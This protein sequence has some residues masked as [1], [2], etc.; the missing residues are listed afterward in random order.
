VGKVVNKRELAEILGYSE[1]SLT[2]WQGAGMPMLSQGDRG[3]EN[4]YDT[5]AVIKW[6]V[7]RESGKDKVEGEKERLTRLQADQ[8]ELDM[9]IKLRDLVP[10]A[11]VEFADAR[12]KEAAKSYL[13]EQAYSLAHVLELTQGT[14][15]KRDLLIETFDSF[16][17]KLANPDIP[18]DVD[19]VE[20]GVEAPG[21]AAA[22]A[23]GRMGGAALPPA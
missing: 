5:E 6:L 7:A 18:E 21:A 14:D 1:R 10:V 13:R 11:E 12:L 17:T 2:D 8:I 22:N 15:A 9:R 4:Q 23:A 19:V 20:E 16:L 3:E